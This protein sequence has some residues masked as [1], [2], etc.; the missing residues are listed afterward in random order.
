MPAWVSA[1]KSVD[2]PTFGKPTIPHLTPIFLSPFSDSPPP[3]LA[4][5]GWGE[6]NN[7]YHPHPGPLD[8]DPDFVL[9]AP[10][11]E[12]SQ[13]EREFKSDG[14]AGH[15]WPAAIAREQCLRYAR[16]RHGSPRPATSVPPPAPFWARS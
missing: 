13:R 10:S 9:P 3:A 14:Y 6:G 1:L 11:L 15:S 8:S 2:L 4:G 16:S 7:P 5:E 12:S